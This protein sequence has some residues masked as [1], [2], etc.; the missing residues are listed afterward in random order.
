[1][2]GLG[3]IS[4]LAFGLMLATAMPTTA[5]TDNITKEQATQAAIKVKNGSVSR[6]TLSKLDGQLVWDIR[7]DKTAVFVDPRTGTII[8]TVENADSK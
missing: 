7:I 8:K 2:K 5:A 6:A 1:M 4:A 3:V